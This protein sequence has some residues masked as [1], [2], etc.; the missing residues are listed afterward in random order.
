MTVP[1]GTPVIRAI[2]AY[3]YP[4]ASAR[5]TVVARWPGSSRSACL[6]TG[7]G[8]RASA[9]SSAELATAVRSGA[10]GSMM[11]SGNSWGRRRRAR[12]DP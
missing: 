9:A 7:S 5:Q 6:S 12:Q 11:S 2:S 1:S 10:A 3:V 4:S 8:M